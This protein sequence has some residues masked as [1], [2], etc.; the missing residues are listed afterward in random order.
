MSGMVGRSPSISDISWGRVTVDGVG[1]AKDVKLYPG[2]GRAWDWRETG[3]GHVPGILPADV[4]ELVE[5]GASVV[6]LSRGFQA[7]LQVHP[8]TL[9][10]LNDRGVRVHVEDTREAVDLYNRLAETEPAGGLFHSTC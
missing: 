8:Q 4:A 9:E 5:G 1:T 3:T 10:L 6:V 2:G 7:R